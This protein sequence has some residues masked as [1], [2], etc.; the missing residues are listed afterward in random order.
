MQKD[1]KIWIIYKKSRNFN[2]TTSIYNEKQVGLLK[3][4]NYLCKSGK[5]NND[6]IDLILVGSTKKKIKDKSDLSK[7]TWTKRRTKY[8]KLR[9]SWNHNHIIHINIFLWNN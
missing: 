5:G 9:L 1:K 4:E 8:K 3:T 2:Q 7:Q 6:Y